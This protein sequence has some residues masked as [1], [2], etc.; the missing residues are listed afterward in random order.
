MPYL[1][2]SIQ[3]AVHDR[4]VAEHD[5]LIKSVKTTIQTSMFRYAKK[6]LRIVIDKIQCEDV[7][8]NSYLESRLERVIGLW[9]EDLGYP[10]ATRCQTNVSGD[11]MVSTL[12]VQ[13]LPH[14]NLPVLVGNMDNQQR[15]NETS[16]F[17]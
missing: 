13:L 11:V 8:I 12:V 16:V 3:K 7:L 2:E 17:T 10:N 15:N 9:L 1:N 4:I 14:Y 5:A 6:N